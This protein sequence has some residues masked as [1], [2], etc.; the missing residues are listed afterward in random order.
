MEISRDCTKKWQKK[1]N[2]RVG[3]LRKKKWK[4]SRNPKRLNLRIDILNMGVQIFSGKA[5][6]RDL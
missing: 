3:G 4:K 6:G 5:H 1:V 2:F